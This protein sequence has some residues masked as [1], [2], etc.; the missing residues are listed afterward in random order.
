VPPA[1]AVT[2]HLLVI[3]KEPIAGRVKTRLTPPYTPEQAASLAAAAI[4]DTMAAVLAAV[5][6]ARAHGHVVEPVLVLDGEPGAWLHDLLEVPFAVRVI[7]QRPGGLDARLAGA[8]EDATRGTGSTCALLVGMDTPQLTGTLLADAIDTLAAPDC[9]AVLGLADDGGWW[10]LGVRRA[11][12]AL[13]LGVPMST[14]ETGQEQHER[15]IG[16]GLSV[17]LLGRLRDVDTAADA[18]QVAAL[19]PRGRFAATLSRLSPSK[20]AA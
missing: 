1:A 4:A 7:P 8:F 9:D 11:D 12:P 16:A 19:A 6:K 2:C 10:T 18:D 15:L 20:P 14:S 5:P 17:S 13:L 3:A